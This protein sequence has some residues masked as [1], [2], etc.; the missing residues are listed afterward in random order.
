MFGWE[1]DKVLIKIRRLDLLLD[2]I[3]YNH[4][5]FDIWINVENKSFKPDLQLRTVF[6]ILKALI[7]AFQK[8][9][10]KR[11]WTSN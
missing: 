10:W 3:V 4:V 8:M 11:R 6:N 7:K 9:F 5:S 2:C 1:Y